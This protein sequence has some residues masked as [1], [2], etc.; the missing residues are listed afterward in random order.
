V[1]AVTPTAEFASLVYGPGGVA[2]DDPAETFHEASSLYPG[3][4]PGRVLSLLELARSPALQETVARASYTRE[5]F[6]GTELPPVALGRAR[7]SDV[8]LARRSRTPPDRRALSLAA[9]ASI[10]GAAYRSGK[11]A[12]SVPSAGALYPLELYL[13]AL[14]VEQVE[15]GVHHYDPYGHRLELLHAAERAA[16]ARALVEP[17][18]AEQAAAVIVVTAMFWR[19][20]FKYG[21][22]G[23]RFALLEAGHVMQNAVLAATALGV[24]ARPL[25]GYY[26]RLLDG[27]VG[28]DSL[29]EASVYALVLG[30]KA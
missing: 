8:L 3:V 11:E 19:S 20:R 21:L 27:L 23:Y 15:H 17:A 7:L 22:R 14:D 13:I 5:Q 12:R 29:D 9:L 2:F 4:A 28:A 10:L 18:L 26:D 25:G 30:G 24:P 1:T 16:V 6:V